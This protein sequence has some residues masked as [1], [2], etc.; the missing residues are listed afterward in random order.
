MSG[1][2]VRGR[3]RCMVVAVMVE[4]SLDVGDIE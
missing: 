1:R 3:A 2:R 4:V